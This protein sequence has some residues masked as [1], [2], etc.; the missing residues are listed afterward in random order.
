MAENGS[1]TSLLD[2]L[3]V[4][5]VERYQTTRGKNDEVKICHE[6]IQGSNH[7]FIVVQNQER[8]FCDILNHYR[9][10]TELAHERM[11]HLRKINA[12][13]PKALCFKML[14]DDDID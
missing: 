12:K 8:L 3:M 7:K 11:L 14:K 2:Y 9:T 6:Q 13:S 4:S 5:G 10:K 1:H